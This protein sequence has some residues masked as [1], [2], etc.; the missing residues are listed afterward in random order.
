MKLPDF[1]NFSPFN[2]LRQS[3]GAEKL[4]SFDLIISR[5]YTNSKEKKE[6]ETSGVE[7]DSLD[8]IYELQDG[9]LAYKD[10]R[11]LLYI[12]DINTSHGVYSQ[13]NK[14]PKFHVAWCQTLNH[15]QAS[16]RF[17]RYVLSTRTDGIFEI[18][19]V[20]RT[21]NDTISSNHSL[22][23]CKHCLNKLH[24]KGYGKNLFKNNGIYKE[25]S[26]AIFFNEYPTSPL[27]SKP[28]SRYTSA[29]APTDVYPNNFQEI[30]LK[31]REGVNWKCEKCGDD[32]A[33]FKKYLH[34]HHIN[35]RKH[36]NN[37]SNLKALCIVCHAKEPSH[38]SM[39][40]MPDYSNYLKIA[41]I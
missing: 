20:G 8:D 32:L 5:E 30:S 28:K 9:T 3:M 11:I 2:K 35:G 17:D 10:T 18:R 21:E 24:Y 22:H 34:T 12:R 23:V 27:N 25:F 1:L 41:K 26:T 7:I 40:Y 13:N 29:S 15:M 33:N 6:L 14:L 31:Y 37:S 39:K 4:G 36:N 16:K 19:K 38:G